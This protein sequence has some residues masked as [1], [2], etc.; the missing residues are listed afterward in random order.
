MPPKNRR[1]DVV[2]ASIVAL[3]SYSQGVNAVTVTQIVTT[4]NS[5]ASP[6]E[7]KITHNVPAADFFNLGSDGSQSDSFQFYVFDDD[8]GNPSKWDGLAVDPSQSDGWEPSKER[9]H[10]R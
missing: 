1:V 7:P 9:C 4:I 8:Q 5:S 10:P 2:V 6:I 3:T